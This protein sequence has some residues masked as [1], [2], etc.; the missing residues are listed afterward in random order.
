MHDL[1]D[2]IPPGLEV[3]LGGFPPS[4]QIGLDL[5]SVLT[6]IPRRGIRAIVVRGLLNGA[7]RVCHETNI[8]KGEALGL[9]GCVTLGLRSGV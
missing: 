7:H 5:I 6:W 1:L 3:L 4:P 2:L 9:D 8:A